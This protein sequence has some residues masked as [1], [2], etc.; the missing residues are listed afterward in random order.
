MRFSSALQEPPYYAIPGVEDYRDYF[1]QQGM[2]YQ[3]R[4][5]SPLQLHRSEH[6]VGYPLLGALYAY[7]ERFENF[8]RS[9]FSE[10]QLKLILSLFLGRKKIL[11][12]PDKNRI[13]ELGI[14][15]LFVVSGFHISLL[16]LVLHFPLRFL[17][18]GGRLLSLLGMWSYVIL[19]GCGPPVLRAGLMATI[20]YLLAFF[21]LFR[22]FL[23]TLGIAALL[24]LALSPISLYS[25]SFQFSFLCLSAIG[26]FLLPSALFI[27]NACRGFED[28]FRGPVVA[29]RDREAAVRRRVRFFLEEKLQFWPRRITGWTLGRAGKSL[30]YFWGLASCGWL[31]Q[32]WTL[33]LSLYYS[34]TWVWTQCLSNL[35][36][37]PLFAIF[38]PLCLA[39]FLTYW[40]PVASIL[41]AGL[42]LYSNI[43]HGLILSL[44]RIAWV[45]YLRQPEPAELAAYFLLFLAIYY[46]PWRLWGRGTRRFAF[47]TPALFFTILQP[48][49]V[50]P[51]GNLQITMLDVGQGE[52]IHLRYPDGSDALVDTGGFLSPRRTANSQI[53]GRQLVSRYLWKERSGYLQYVLLTHAHADHTQGYDFLRR[54]FPIRQLFLHDLRE[55]YRGPSVRILSAG[56]QF[57]LG[58]V[59]HFVLH[60][61]ER[62][63]YTGRWSPNNSSLVVLLRYKGFSMLFTGDIDASVERRLLS[64][65]LPVTILKAAHHGSSSSN[66]EELL[67]MAQPMLAIISAGRKN[68]FGHPSAATLAR[69]AKA[70]VATLTTS[71]WG[72]L[73]IETDGYHW[74]VFH[75]S[76]DQGRFLEVQLPTPRPAGQ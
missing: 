12:E 50:P 2:L 43:L 52:S 41:V 34:N 35:I 51:D 55:E 63:P 48:G 10:I 67:Q 16:L 58:G 6:S 42:R 44:R 76:I 49:S 25:P 46:S 74:K 72:S 53:V 17:G 9:K 13:R 37:V 66:S 14:Y 22:Q 38:L 1:W 47:L 11:E 62:D 36:F 27:R 40:L 70:G 3:A 69:L 23:N 33:P 56:D 60:P 15:H 65:L 7:T 30:C 31:L 8:C 5:K 64:G 39:L 59:A 61:Q 4:L 28:F 68:V 73:R 45:D 21:G 26:L 54:A 75:Y 71:Q 29:G 20:F 19:V 18:L 57:V 32:W 24:I